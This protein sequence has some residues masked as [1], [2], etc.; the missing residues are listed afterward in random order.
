MIGHNKNMDLFA[1][2][3]ALMTNQ[4]ILLQIPILQQPVSKIENQASLFAWAMIT[5]QSSW[6]FSCWRLL[7]IDQKCRCTSSLICQKHEFKHRFFW[8]FLDFSLP[9]SLPCRCPPKDRRGRG[10]PPS[11]R[12]RRW[13][14]GRGRW[15]RR[16]VGTCLN[17]KIW[18]RKSK[19]NVTCRLC[20]STLAPQWG[21][22]QSR[23]RLQ[24]SQPANAN[25]RW[26]PFL[27]INFQF[28]FEV[29]LKLPYLSVDGRNDCMLVGINLL[30]ASLQPPDLH[31]ID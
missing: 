15:G 6:D 20:G 9:W 23:R 18:K 1:H 24:K 19:R 28:L 22:R 2:V 29:L 3:G 21:Q 5:G 17:F 10:R 12:W 16:C 13:T 27:I 31:L 26:D 14:W 8:D 25:V 30:K 7:P 4:I 11:T